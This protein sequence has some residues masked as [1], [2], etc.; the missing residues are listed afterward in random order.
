MIKRILVALDMES[1]TTVATQYAVEIGTRHEARLTGLAVVDMGS[2]EASSHGGGIGTMYY[3]EKIRE[4]LTDDAREKARKLTE[5]FGDAAKAV[6]HIELVQEG[7]PFERIVEDMKFHDILIVGDDPHFFY[8][9]PHSKTDTLVHVVEKTIGPT[10]VVQKEYRAV[11]KVM[12]AY[13]GS[14]EA[15]RALRRYILLKPFGTETELL[16]LH[17]HK[18]D[19]DDSK[20]VL[21]L[22]KS[23]AEAHGFT[24]NTKSMD[25]HD[26]KKAILSEANA[27]EVDLIVVGVHVKRTL[28]GKKLGETTAFLLKNSDVPVFMDH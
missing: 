3:A 24:V 13:D 19:I 7:V 9:H 6:E 2:I 1:D 27:S 20:L 23:Y 21:S 17:I 14:D 11:K 15:S 18:G 8:S 16:I 25:D 12:I 26:P 28:T 10:L 4:Q 22:A 5:K